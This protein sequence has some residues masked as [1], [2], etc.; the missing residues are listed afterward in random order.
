MPWYEMEAKTYFPPNPGPYELVFL[1]GADQEI[2]GYTQAFT[3]G[4]TLQ[5]AGGAAYPDDYAFFT[6]ATRYPAATARIQIRQTGPG[7]NVL[8]QENVCLAVTFWGG[9]AETRPEGAYVDDVRLRIC[10]EGLEDYC[11]PDLVS[12]G[13]K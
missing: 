7:G 1:D 4:T 3:V 9:A 5:Y 2:V 12:S 11:T 13:A 10:P 8:G 6:F